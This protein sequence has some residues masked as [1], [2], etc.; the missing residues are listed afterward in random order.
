[1]ALPSPGIWHECWGYIGVLIFLA[2][3]ASVAVA[4][5]F[6]SR[7]ITR[8]GKYADDWLA[9]FTLLVHHGL[10]AVVLLAFFADGL[11]FNT[12]TLSAAKQAA[13]D[14]EASRTIE[15]HKLTFTG[16]I[17]YGIVSTSVRLAV[18]KFH[19]RVFPG[20]AIKR[21]GYALAA[22]CVAWFVVI[23]GL[24]LGTCQPVAFTWNRNMPGGHCVNVRAAFV[25]V[26]AIDL[27]IDAATV[28]L[29]VREVSKLE[30]S[31][32]KRVAVLT[33]FLLGG[34][35]TLA[36]LARLVATS[37]YLDTRLMNR[38]GK[39]SA[40]LWAATCIEIYFAIIASCA[41][42][43]GPAYMTL[44]GRPVAILSPRSDTDD[45]PIPRPHPHPHPHGRYTTKPKK[46]LKPKSTTTFRSSDDEERPFTTAT[47]NHNNSRGKGKRFDATS[48]VHQILVPAKDRGEFWTDITANPHPKALRRQPQ[49]ASSSDVMGEEQEQEQEQEEVEVEVEPGRIRV[50]RDVITSTWKSEL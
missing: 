35:A 2:A 24:V 17:L 44:C 11:G 42:T 49:P 22:I 3:A 21:G 7:W 33:V 19:L 47:N 4:L 13:T 40:L 34:I 39:T 8:E 46:Q 48:E 26:G 16:T 28:C 9:L 15:L 36:C 30:L 12:S 50:Q 6:W 18:I 14:V 32:R 43:L 27:V 41:P 23:E 29:P 25:S 45:T 10:L 38:S 5:R 1:M 31:R 20:K 37:L